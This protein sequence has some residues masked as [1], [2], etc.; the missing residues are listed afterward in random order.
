MF[1]LPTAATTFL[2]YSSGS[3]VIWLSDIQCEG[4]ESRLIDCPAS[5]L[6]IHN[7]VHSE[8]VGVAC[9]T[10]R[11]TDG[12]IRLQGRVASEGHLQIC[13]SN[14]WGSVCDSSWY[15]SNARV[16]CRQLGLQPTSKIL[17][18]SEAVLDQYVFPSPSL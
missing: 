16:V 5:P 12:D 14:V 10:T 18:L 15:M 2:G 7:C 13:L 3:G 4:N 8:D 9:S 11:C 6:G 17:K 1:F